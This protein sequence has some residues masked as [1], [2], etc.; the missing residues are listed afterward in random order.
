MGLCKFYRN[1]L[2]S[3][4]PDLGMIREY[5]EK[6]KVMV[7]GMGHINFVSWRVKNNFDTWKWSSSDPR[8]Y[9]RGQGTKD[10]FFFSPFS[11]SPEDFLMKEKQP[12]V[13]NG[14]NNS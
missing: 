10:L 1:A 7:L 3:L 11:I 8:R 4:A 9:K 6:G 2:I 5:L 13:A 12:G 14:C